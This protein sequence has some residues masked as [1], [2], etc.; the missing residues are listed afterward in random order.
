MTVGCL[1]A[2]DIDTITLLG[3]LKRQGQIV[4]PG[5]VV[6]IG[7]QQLANS[8]LRAK[9]E[10]DEL[11]KLFGVTSPI[12]LPAPVEGGMAHGNLEH[13]SAQAPSSRDFWEWLGYR[14]A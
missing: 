5:T 12:T 2:L 1:V 4:R 10:L 7:A 13:L 14:Y 6:E 3:R 9:P 8:F 11:G